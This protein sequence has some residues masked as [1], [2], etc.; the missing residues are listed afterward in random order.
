MD[1]TEYREESRKTWN[2]MAESWDEAHEER[3]LRVRHIANWLL[4][5]LD[6]KPGETILDI[7][8]GNGA[9]SHELS[10]QVGDSGRV[11][12]TDFAPAMVESARRRGDELGLTNVDYREMDAERMDLDDASVDGVV[13]RFG[14]MLMADPVA[15]LKETRRVLRDD[16]RLTFAVWGEP[17]KNPWVLVPGSVLIERGHMQMPEAGAPGILALGGVD[18]IEPALA[19]AGLEPRAITELPVHYV[20]PDRDTMWEHVATRMGPLARVASALP[21]DEQRAV[22]A[23]IEERAEPFRDGDGYDVPGMAIAVHAMPQ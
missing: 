8:A 14:Y 19:A 1:R 17:M 5:W 2:E 22:R 20:Y 11:I 12:C 6:A 7:A 16:G 21:E 15:A 13:C 10:P 23:A 18:K 3:D 9:I 4:G